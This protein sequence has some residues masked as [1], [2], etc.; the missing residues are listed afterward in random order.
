MPASPLAAGMAALSRAT[1]E[2]LPLGGSYRAS[3]ASSTAPPTFAP[4]TMAPALQH[5]QKKKKQESPQFSPPA[6]PRMRPCALVAAL[7]RTRLRAALGANPCS[8]L[9]ALG[10]LAPAARHAS[11]QPLLKRGRFAPSS[12]L[13][14]SLDTAGLHLTPDYRVDGARQLVTGGGAAA[15]AQ[16]HLALGVV[17]DLPPSGVRDRQPWLAVARLCLFDGAKFHGNAQVAVQSGGGAL[18]DMVGSMGRSLARPR[19]RTHP[20]LT[21]N[22]GRQAKIGQDCQERRVH[23]AL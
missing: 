18:G 14:P 21:F 7:A 23:L 17:Q 2:V 10:S 19:P 20:A 12:L 4:A 9:S 8:Y 3:L 6:W 22:P 11:L 13:W 1:S 15:V 16:C 5:Q